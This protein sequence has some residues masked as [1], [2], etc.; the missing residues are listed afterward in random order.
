MFEWFVSLFPLIGKLPLKSFDFQCVVLCKHG[1]F[2]QRLWIVPMGLSGL[3]FAGSIP[4]AR[5]KLL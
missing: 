4:V 1:E 2:P 5:S 3:M